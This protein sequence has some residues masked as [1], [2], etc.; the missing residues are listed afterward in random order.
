MTMSFKKA[1]KK[2]SKM[3]RKRLK[4]LRKQHWREMKILKAQKSYL[5]CALDD[6]EYMGKKYGQ[7]PKA[8]SRGRR[9]NRA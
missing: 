8:R 2:R 1:L 6:I 7:A 9:A 3:V 4:R 5:E